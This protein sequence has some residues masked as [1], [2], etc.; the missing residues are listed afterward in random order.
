M[1]RRKDP[2]P[3]TKSRRP[4]GVETSTKA[5]MARRLRTIKAMWI[6][7]KSRDEI[8]EWCMTLCEGKVWKVGLNQA[9]DYF[10]R[11]HKEV[12]EEDVVGRQ[13]RRA[14]LA[15][16]AERYEI[17]AASD[18]DWDDALGFMKF[19]RDLDGDVPPPAPA[20]DPDDVPLVTVT[21]RINT[22]ALTRETRDELRAMARK[23]AAQ[24]SPPESD[25]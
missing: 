16:R 4:R 10:Q 9:Q 6:G 5:E 3:P 13:S 2:P 21:S 18:K 11:A 25:E 7:G 17:T 1:G 22:K 19:Q 14:K 12:L 15:A 8:I 24:I 20:S 23:V